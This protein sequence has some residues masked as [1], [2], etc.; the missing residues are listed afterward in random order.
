VVALRPGC[1]ALLARARMRQQLG[2]SAGVLSDLDALI[3]A[4]KDAGDSITL[5]D[6]CALTDDVARQRRLLERAS[7]LGNAD[8][9]LRLRRLR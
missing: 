9:S 7:Q 5:V 2:D 3:A 4:A 1:P 8:A 6:A